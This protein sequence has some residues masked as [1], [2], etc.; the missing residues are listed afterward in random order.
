[1]YVPV[2][3]PVCPST[4]AAEPPP[5]RSTNPG[6]TGNVTPYAI[7]TAIAAA[8]SAAKAPAERSERISPA[9]RGDGTVHDQSL[10][11]E[12]A[13]GQRDRPRAAIALRGDD[14]V[15]ARAA[16]LELERTRRHVEPP[17]AVSD[18]ADLLQRLLA[19]R[20]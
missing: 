20:L 11:V 10:T 4:S 1:M 19:T 16:R 17:D 18:L 2:S 6:S 14:L 3:Q 13:A 15:N 9:G 12:I 7:D 5:A 8:S